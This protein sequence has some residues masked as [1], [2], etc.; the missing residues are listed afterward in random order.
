VLCVVKYGNVIAIIVSRGNLG[1]YFTIVKSLWLIKKSRNEF[2][3]SKSHNWLVFD[4]E[5]GT[6]N[7]ENILKIYFNRQK[8]EGVVYK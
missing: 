5:F 3:D 4:S 6:T 8:E 2:L 1:G 7:H